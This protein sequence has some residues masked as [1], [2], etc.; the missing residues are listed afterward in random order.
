MSNEPDEESIEAS[1]MTL[2]EHLE[3]LRKRLAIGLGS[4]VVLFVLTWT[5]SD[6][7]TEIVL[8]P[9]HVTVSKLEAFY[10][11]EAE[12]M[13]RDDPELQ[14]EELFEKIG[15]KERLR[16]LGDTRMTSIAPGE[17]FFFKLKICLYFSAFL[18][19]PILLWQLWMFVAA[20]LYQQEKRVVLGFFPAAFALFTGGVVFGYYTL[21]PYG[22]YFLN[23]TTDIRLIRMDL[24]VQEY[25]TFL[26]SLCLALGVVFQLPIAMIVL[27]R[28]DIVRA[29]TMSK[30]RGHT[31]VLAVVL[32]AFLT[33]PDP[34]TQ[35]MMAVPIVVLY[36]VGIWCARLVAPKSLPS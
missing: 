27:S 15:D 14:R 5:W 20:G 18:G 12:Q 8:R 22:M 32:A 13:L 25:F 1:R 21:V 10:T 24:R 6:L 30:Y 2:G 9:Y 35:A 36:E 7:A 33:P 16:L 28:L 19:S 26:S 23:R 17:G 4:V 31:L 29:E 34:Y 3:E 11:A